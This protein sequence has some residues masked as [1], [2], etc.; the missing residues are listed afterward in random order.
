MQQLWA[1]VLVLYLGG[2]RWYLSMAEAGAL[3]EHNEDFTV[4]DPIDERVA[5]GFAWT[6]LEAC[7][8]W[9]TSTDVLMRVGIKDPTK[10]QTISAAR[11]LRRLNGGQRKKSNG[12][13]L[14]AIP[15]AG[16][17]FLE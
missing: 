13:V 10:A 9:A 14:F 5:A 7:C 1:E 6:G 17:D 8:E 15:G 11:V 4:T 16:T 12:R 3:G 2:E